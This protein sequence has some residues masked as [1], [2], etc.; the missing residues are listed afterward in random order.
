MNDNNHIALVIGLCSHGLAMTRALTKCGVNVHALEANF[1]LPGAI[2][3]SATV[4]KVASIKQ[5]SLIDDLLSFRKQFSPTIKIVL[6]PT[7]DNNV[8]IIST[9]IQLLSEH[10]IISWGHCA[11]TVA[12]L[13][14][15]SNI[16]D[17]CV[18]TGL[19]YPKSLVISDIKGTDTAIGMF[20]FPVIIKPVN[21]QSSFKALRCDSPEQLRQLVEQYKQDLPI[22]VQHWISGGDTDLYFCALYLDKGK[23]LTHYLGNKLASFPPAM[24]Q[25]TVAVSCDETEL[26]ELTE[27]FFDGLNMSGPVSVEYKKDQQGRY[28]VIEPTVGRSDFW[29]GLCIRSGCN[30]PYLEYQTCLKLP[31]LAEAI[32]PAIWFDSERDVTAFFKHMIQC[33]VPVGGKHHPAFSYLDHSDLQPFYRAMKQATKRLIVKVFPEKSYKIEQA[34]G[35]NEGQVLEYHSL[36]DLPKNCLV[37]LRKSGEANFFLGEDWYDNFCQ[38]VPDQNEL[39]RFYCL[40]DLQGNAQAILPAWIQIRKMLGFHHRT[41]TSLTNYYSPI[42]DLSI[43]ETLIDK[44]N[45]YLAFLSYFQQHKNQW[46]IIDF[47]PL[48]PEIN[49]IISQQAKKVS[50]PCF[51][52]FKTLNLYEPNIASFNTYIDS[53]EAKIKNTLKRKENKLTRKFDWSVEILFKPDDICVSMPN[54]HQVYNASWKEQEP[55]PNFINGMAEIAAKKNNLR[56]GLLKVNGK[57]IATQLWIVANNTAYIY[58]LAYNSDYSEYSPGT[59]LTKHMFEYVLNHDKIT[60]VDFLTG[61]DAYKSDWMSS[62]RMLFGVQ[63]IS[64]RRF[65]GVLI[66]AVDYLSKLRKKLK[67]MF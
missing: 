26:I 25:T 16:E 27:R 29:V 59:V 14:L 4:H 10:Y 23:V 22:L 44:S 15:K 51:S 24:G 13:L 50:L 35:L 56:L 2:T 64:F 36:A 20:E 42:F 62:R 37:L 39:V 1:E 6:I 33:K 3:N 52:Y 11:D 46:D 49:E 5:D 41:I 58:K 31:I 43:D 8:K 17:R 63:M 60:K 9:N 32:K 48:A 34:K 67:K 30:L 61:D 45:A 53:R 57:A 12:A 54:Y 40:F 47:A 38:H 65:R 28:W 19:H 7:N 55:Y 66:Y 18:Q 21:P